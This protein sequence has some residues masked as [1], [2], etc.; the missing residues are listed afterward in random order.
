M[1]G[2]SSTVADGWNVS[3]Y[4]RFNI[5]IRG[6]FVA[7]TLPYVMNTSVIPKILAKIREAATP[8][9]F[10]QD[11]LSTVLGFSGGNAKPFIPLAKR[12][13]LLNSDGTPTELYRRFRGSQ[14]ESRAAMGTAVR[15]GYGPLFK[16]NEYADKLDRKK[17]EGLITEI[18][19]SEAGSSTVKATSGTFEALKQ[20]ATFSPE[21][22]S[23]SQAEEE[24]PSTTAEDTT[25]VARSA[26]NDGGG[27]RFGYTININLPNTNDIAVFNAIFKSLKEHLL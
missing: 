16:R 6:G 22:D 24:R 20:F 25:F 1:H 4:D 14:D 19:G 2:R 27:V 17:L 13:G 12:I 15:T 9:R 23:P 3:R 8:D 18:T 21:S 10:S 26:V 5:P 7:E 11:Y